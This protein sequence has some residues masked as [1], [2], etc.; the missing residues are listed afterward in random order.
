MEDSIFTKI[1]RGDI[2]SYKIYEDDY[3]YAF[4]DI[5][6]VNPGHTLVISKTQVDHLWDL[7]DKD[8]QFLMDSVKKVAKRLSEVL[9]PARVG[10]A[11]EGFDVA[12]AHIHL[13][14]IEAGLEK[15]LNKPKT[16]KNTPEDLSAMANRLFFEAKK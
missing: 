3:S 4:L 7:S 14:P 6:P 1:I 9:K 16:D 5:N 13:I 11:V 10:V 15:E 8:Y 2:P 12:H